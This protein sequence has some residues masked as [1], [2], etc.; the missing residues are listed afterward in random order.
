MIYEV[1][2]V[3]HVLSVVIAAGAVGVIDYLHIVGLRKKKLE[4]SAIKIYPAI[5][6]LI[7]LAFFAIILTGVALVVQK[8]EMLSNQL[9]RVKIALVILVGLN[10]IYLQRKVGP[11]LEVCAIKGNKYCFKNVLYYSAIAGTFS[12]VT[13]F[14]I[15]LL[16]LTKNLGYNWKQFLMAY[17]I[18][19]IIGIFFGIGMEKK[20]RAWR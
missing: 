16:S 5:S 3:S 18:I 6:K 11:S 12:A 14:A 19:L 4:K 9:F 10:G 20:A 1:N 13:W 2:L 17:V 8:P 7:N 15:L